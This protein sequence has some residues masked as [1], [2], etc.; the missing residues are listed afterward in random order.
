MQLGSM[1]TDQGYQE[2]TRTLHDMK[3]INGVISW[4]VGLVHSTCLFTHLPDDGAQRPNIACQRPRQPSAGLQHLRSHP[5]HGIR[6]GS[7]LPSL[8]VSYT[9]SH[10]KIGNFYVLLLGEQ[11]VHRVQGIVNY[12]FFMHAVQPLSHVQNRSPAPAT[13]QPGLRF[14]LTF[15]PV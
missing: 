11:D 15:R 5:W 9:P 7:A 6:D 14:L 12:S 1:S 2:L 3:R 8:L 13:R 4:G 10:P